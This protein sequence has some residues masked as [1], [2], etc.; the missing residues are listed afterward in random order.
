[1]G[2][3]GLDDVSSSGA[4]ASCTPS[5]VFFREWDARAPGDRRSLDRARALIEAL[6]INT[7]GIP[8]LTVVGSKGKG[9]AAA[10]AS[11]VV[12]AAGRRVVTITS[13]HYRTV[14]E[15]I[16]V[17]GSAVSAAG[18]AALAG[19]ISGG[20][21]RLPAPRGGYLAPSGLFIVAGVLH[22][23]DLD[24]DALVVEAGR[25]GRSDEASL[26]PPTVAAVTPVFEEHLGELGDSV[27]DIARDKAS[28]IGPNTL[29]V[30]SA[31]QRDDVEPVLRAAVAE[32]SGGR[33]AYEPARPG[34]VPDVP[35]GPLPGGLGA[36]NAELGYLAA[37]R[38]LELTG[39]TRPAA[40][41]LR[42]VLSS[43]S[44]PGRLSWHPVPEAPV[45]VLLDQAVNGP[46]AAAARTA[47]RSRGGADHVLVSLSDDKDLDGVI[48]ALRGLPV[49]FVRLDRPH[50]GF[51]RPVPAHWTVLGEH[52]LT[53][54]ALTRLGGRVI[55]LGNVSFVARMLELLDVSAEPLFTLVRRVD[56]HPNDH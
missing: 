6:R 14:R 20:M 24:A 48:A 27:A 51:T 52:E 42:A 18:L 22:A 34:D 29:A 19:R 23:L 54:R 45:S 32:A 56:R 50:L 33:T 1:M 13:P 40:E 4:S 12:S 21:A 37:R 55:A 8:V 3:D 31:P 26:F 46:G 44:L 2:F 25:G 15:R 7:A 9:T 17:D 11:A 28:V 30:L 43:M 5:R 10:Y 47:A 49:T 39:G 38:L 41:P 35:P 53:V 36:A 16:R